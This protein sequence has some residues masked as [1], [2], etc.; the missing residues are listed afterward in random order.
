MSVTI[1][2]GVLAKAM[3][4]VREALDFAPDGWRVAC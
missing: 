3:K 4:P 2:T 1:D